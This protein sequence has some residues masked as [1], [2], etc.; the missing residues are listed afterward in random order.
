VLDVSALGPGES[1]AL[2]VRQ[3]EQ[4]H[5][6]A[7]V[8]RSYRGLTLSMM[9]VRAGEERRWAE[10]ALPDSAR[11]RLDLRARGYELAFMHDDVV[12]MTV[13][14]RELDASSTGGFLGL[15]LGVCATSAGRPPA[16]ELGIVRFAYAPVE[17]DAPVERD[18]AGDVA[19][20][21]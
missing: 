3:S 20:S 6:A 14:A 10:Q 16:G 17:G 21:G 4:D 12:S 11:V 15:W 18:A 8:T 7:V 5:A 19:A 2:V 1:G 9:H 13:D